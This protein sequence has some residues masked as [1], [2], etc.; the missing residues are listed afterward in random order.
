F[1]GEPRQDRHQDAVLE[2]ATEAEGVDEP[3]RGLPLRRRQR[4]TPY[5]PTVSG[6]WSDHTPRTPFGFGPPVPAAR[7]GPWDGSNGLRKHIRPRS[8]L[9]EYVAGSAG[10]P[11]LCKTCGQT[12]LIGT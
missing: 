10:T 5:F 1:P 8:V 6:V 7:R 2:K 12:C 11:R 9:T 3:R 4:A